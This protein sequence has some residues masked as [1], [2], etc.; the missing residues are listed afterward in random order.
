MRHI[1]VLMD[2]LRFPVT[3]LPGQV[4]NDF[5]EGHSVF[6]IYEACALCTEQHENMTVL[7]MHDDGDVICIDHSQEY[8]RWVSCDVYDLESALEMNWFIS[9]NMHCAKLFED[10]RIYGHPTRILI[11]IA[12]HAEG[13]YTYL[14]SL[15]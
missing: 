1:F 15:D 13:F 8:P 3:S 14:L 5:L 9:G 11:T 4:F 2:K 6:D 7:L 12:R 10:F